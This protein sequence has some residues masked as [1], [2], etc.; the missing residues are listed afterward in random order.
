MTSDQKRRS[1]SSPGGENPSKGSLKKITKQR[2]A[3]NRTLA[4][5][6]FAL[7]KELAQVFKEEELAVVQMTDFIDRTP[8]CSV[9]DDFMNRLTHSLRERRI[10]LE[11]HHRRAAQMSGILK[12]RLENEGVL[13]TEGGPLASKGPV[14]KKLVGGPAP[15]D[16]GPTFAG[17]AV[18]LPASALAKPNLPRPPSIAGPPSCSVCRT[19]LAK[20]DHFA[21]CNRENLVFHGACIEP[22]FDCPKCDDNLASF[23]AYY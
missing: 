6:A 22:M 21:R 7:L 12:Q 23:M 4:L 9:N 20:G 16:K 11:K 8:V 2:K 15:A 17:T 18:T 10:L 19:E 1:P 5:E 14:A 3:L 13:R